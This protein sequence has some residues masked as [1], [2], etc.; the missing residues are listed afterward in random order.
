MEHQFAEKN[1]RIKIGETPDFLRLEWI[2]SAD[3][4]DTDT[5]IKQFLY[6]LK[7][8]AIEKGQKIVLDFR[9]LEYISTKY[10][11]MVAKLVLSISE[12]KGKVEVLM[13][14]KVNWQRFSHRAFSTL[15]SDDNNILII[16][17]DC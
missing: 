12:E 7:D 15:T 17:S 5:A 4:H 10:I 1:L 16:D 2:G 14:T 13:D 6:E 11:A 8:R 9:S 3:A